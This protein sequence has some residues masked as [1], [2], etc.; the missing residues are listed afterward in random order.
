MDCLD[1]QWLSNAEYYRMFSRKVDER[2]IPVSGSLA[3]TD[4]CNLRCIHCYLGQPQAVSQELTAAQWLAIIDDITRN[5]CL[6]VLLTGGE[7]MLRKDFDTIYRHAKESGL[8]TSVF[9]NGTRISSDTIALF[10]DLPPH[11]LEISL[12]GA[13]E[14]TCAQVTGRNDAYQR[15]R[16]GLDQLHAAGIPFSLKTVLMKANLEDFHA[17]KTLARHYQAEFRFDA[18]IF[19]GLDGDETPLEQRVDPKEAVALE[20]E[21]PDMVSRWKAYLDRQ[22][23]FSP[24]DKLYN[25]GTGLTS[26]HIDAR[27]NL[28]PCILVDRVQY[29]LLQGEFEIG[30]HEVIPRIRD[31]PVNK[32]GE[33]AQC[34]ERSLCGLCPAFFKLETGSEEA[35]SE[36][37]CAM[38]QY[39][40]S[41]IYG[42]NPEGGQNARGQ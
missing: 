39:R 41:T 38:G 3:L 26:F 21:E 13:T 40:F 42:S 4:R 23:A 24:A 11:G 15:C 25:C 30:W 5:G 12:Y 32:T 36:Y 9:T 1:T 18:A 6:Y 33:C 14:K 34:A 16:D 35:K 37:L 31:I 10:Q 8:I 7:P 2:R 17:I 20:L 22:G 27:G 29:N 28:Q 19:P